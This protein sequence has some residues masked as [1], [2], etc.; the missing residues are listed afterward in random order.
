MS[1]SSILAG[2]IGLHILLINLLNGEIQL[3]TS[4]L[5]RSLL[6]PTRP[7]IMDTES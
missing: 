7:D 3:V 2:P 6:F 4:T 5:G 1:T